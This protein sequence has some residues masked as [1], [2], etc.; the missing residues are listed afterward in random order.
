MY[1]V[2]VREDDSVRHYQERMVVILRKMKDI[3]DLIEYENE[4]LW[5]TFDEII[6]QELFEMRNSG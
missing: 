1:D 3:V 4:D 5:R 2:N 6:A